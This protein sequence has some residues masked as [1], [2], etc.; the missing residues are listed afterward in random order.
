MHTIKNNPMYSFLIIL[1]I[2]STAGLQA[3]AILFDNFVINTAG[4]TASH[5][6]ILQSIRE[7]PGFLAMFAVFVVL[8]IKEYR[9][10]ILSIAI[11]GAGVFITG[12]LPSFPGLIFTTLASSLGYHYF[13]TTRQ[14]LTLQHFNRVQTPIVIGRQISV[15]AITSIVVGLFIY[16]GANCISNIHM[17]MVFGAAIFLVAFFFYLPKIRQNLP[18]IL[19]R[20]EWYSRKNTGCFM[21]SLSWE[22]PDGRYS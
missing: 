14:S 3:W 18:G 21:H 9:L 11:L 15:S 10:S 5:A 2:C 4:L 7:I 19:K 12:L 1:T 16:F 20:G 13:E 6:G 17:Y 22:V 8:I